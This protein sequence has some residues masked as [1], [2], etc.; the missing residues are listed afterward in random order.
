MTWTPTVEEYKLNLK[1]QYASLEDNLKS[2]RYARNML[3]IHFAFNH[4]RD[5]L[6]NINQFKQSL[7]KLHSSYDY[8]HPLEDYIIKH[9]VIL[10]EHADLYDTQDEALRKRAEERRY[11]IHDGIYYVL[12]NA[13]K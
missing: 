11:I 10:N 4:I 6:W 8:I 1:V 7:K 3:E 5:D 12:T 2:F 13:K 9:G